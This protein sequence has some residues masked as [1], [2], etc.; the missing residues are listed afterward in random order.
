MA[1]SGQDNSSGAGAGNPVVRLRGLPKKDA[2]TRPS[3]PVMP[4][5]APNRPPEVRFKPRPSSQPVEELSPAEALPP[6]EESVPADALTPAEDPGET[7]T[8]DR[9]FEEAPAEQAD[10]SLRH[11][12][13]PVPVEERGA[14]PAR[15]EPP[16]AGTTDSPA[17]ISLPEAIPTSP[18]LGVASNPSAGGVR[19]HVPAKAAPASMEVPVAPCAA[20]QTGTR[21]LGPSAAPTEPYTPDTD[22]DRIYRRMWWKYDLRVKAG[23]QPPGEAKQQV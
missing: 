4:P 18:D 5:H 12:F 17:A 13:E 14:S 15:V 22:I 7:A 16:Q 10:Q 3:T 8:A 20:G 23:R 21:P 1:G 19:I 11:P 6:V 2:D 9:T